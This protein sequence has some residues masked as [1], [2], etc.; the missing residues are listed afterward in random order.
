MLSVGEG[1]EV[2]GV[3]EPR[4]EGQTVTVLDSVDHPDIRG[5]DQTC[6]SH[7]LKVGFAL[8]SIIKP[9]NLIRIISSLQS[10]CTWSTSRKSPGMSYS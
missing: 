3:L 7:D 5:V 8:C 10:R 6:A 1:F 2:G 4:Q 9:V